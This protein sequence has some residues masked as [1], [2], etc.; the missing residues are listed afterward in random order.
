MQTAVGLP[1]EMVHGGA[2]AAAVYLAGVAAGSLGTSVC[3]PTVCLAGAS[4]GVYALL[5]AHLSNVL[6]NYHTMQWG[7]VRLLAVFVFGMYYI[8]C[9]LYC[10]IIHIQNR[11]N[12]LNSSLSQFLCIDS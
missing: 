2:R 1:L 12:I 9:V 6:L 4:G 3:D 7:A 10:I 8:Y 11:S 5:A